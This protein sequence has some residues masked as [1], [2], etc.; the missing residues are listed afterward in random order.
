VNAQVKPVFSNLAADG[1]TAF[2]RVSAPGD[3][4]TGRQITL[5]WK[6]NELVFDGESHVLVRG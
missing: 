3:L 6:S 2:G 1:T 5:S 4:V